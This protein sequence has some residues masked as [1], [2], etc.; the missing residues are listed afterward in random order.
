VTAEGRVQ[1]IERS[2]I[3]VQQ[4]DRHQAIGLP[5]EREHQLLADGR[6]GSG[7]GK[8]QHVSSQR[9]RDYGSLTGVSKILEL[10]NFSVL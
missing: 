10:S 2:L 6:Q 7:Q 8:L 9:S 4:A 3:A 5:V 1:R